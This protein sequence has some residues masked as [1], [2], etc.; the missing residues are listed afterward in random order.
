[1]PEL[2]PLPCPECGGV[3]YCMPSETWSVHCGCGHAGRYC[4]SEEEAIKAHNALPRALR[5][6]TEPPKVAGWYWWRLSRLNI[7]HCVEVYGSEDGLR[8]GSGESWREPSISV[9]SDAFEWA[10][11]IPRPLD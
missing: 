6:T 3:V 10:G 5:W 9:E 4:T 1:M 11:P 8:V 2:K 7:Q